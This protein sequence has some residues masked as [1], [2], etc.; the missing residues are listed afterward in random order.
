MGLRDRKNG[1]LRMRVVYGEVPPA[2]LVRMPQ[3]EL[4]NP[5]RKQKLQTQ[6][7][8]YDPMP[9]FAA[10][11]SALPHRVCCVQGAGCHPG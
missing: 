3:R 8:E 1:D 4:A 6:D 9:Q 7:A 11:P 10:A 5:E 2:T